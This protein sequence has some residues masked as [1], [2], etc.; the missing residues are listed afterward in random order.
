MFSW[1]NKNISPGY[2]LLSRATLLVKKKSAL[3]GVTKCTFSS[4]VTFGGSVWVHARAASSK[5]PVS[6]VSARFRADSGTNLFKQ[7]EIVPGGPCG[8]VA[9]LARV[10]AQYVRGPGFASRLGHVL[11]PPL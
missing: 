11:F 2:P 9:Q 6:S 4:P 8:L 10:L 3:S 7:G 5:G 1:R